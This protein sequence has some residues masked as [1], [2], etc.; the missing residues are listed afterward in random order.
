MSFQLPSENV[1]Y[2]PGGVPAYCCQAY[3]A[4]YNQLLRDGKKDHESQAV[5]HVERRRDIPRWK[6]PGSSLTSVPSN[7]E[8]IG[9]PLSVRD[10]SRE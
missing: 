6:L 7:S 3:L 10:A 4:A 5:T 1:K 9:A 2:E 8:N